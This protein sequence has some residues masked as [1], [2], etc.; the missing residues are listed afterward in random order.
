M[1]EEE[2]REIKAGVRLF[3]DTNNPSIDLINH[4]IMCDMPALIT[5]LEWSGKVIALLESINQ[6]QGRECDDLRAR[7]NKMD[8]GK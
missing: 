5:D 8:D 2:F 3:K 7:L 4:L 6:R 1:S